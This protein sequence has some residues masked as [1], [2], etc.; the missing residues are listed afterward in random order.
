[1]NALRPCRG[2]RTAARRPP[3]STSSGPSQPHSRRPGIG[4][5]SRSR[6]PGAVDGRLQ[7]RPA[8]GRAPPIG[9]PPSRGRVGSDRGGRACGG[10]AWWRRCGRAGAGGY[11]DRR[12]GRRLA[13]AGPELAT[14]DVVAA[15]DT[16]RL[17]RL[18]AAL[19][20]ELA[21]RVVSYYDANEA[22]RTP[23]LVDG[24]AGRP[25]GAAGHRRR[26]AVGV[27]PR[28]PAGGRRGRGRA[29]AVTAVPGP[30]AV[31][32]ALALSGLPVD[33]F[34][35]EGFLPRKAGERAR[36]LAELADRAAHDGLLRGAAPARRRARRDGRRARRRPAG[37]GLPGDDQDLR[38][39]TPGRAGRAGRLG[40]RRGTRR[41][42]GRGRRG[43][44]GRG[45][46]AGGPGRRGRAAGRRPAYGSRRPPAEVAQPGSAS[47]TTGAG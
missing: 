43:R 14:A 47:L 29:C 4:G 17:R 41:G 8:Y 16:R 36:R 31:L 5:T 12:P 44:A 28:L 37:R 21:G 26:H 19:G 46:G 34:C 25:A 10:C 1:M 7:H 20:V 38:G 2:P 45:G 40:R 9:R 11:A 24:A 18:A 30:S 39:G 3:R 27:R 6:T 32:T 13:A 35:F 15:E 23:E 22:A 33:R 42:H